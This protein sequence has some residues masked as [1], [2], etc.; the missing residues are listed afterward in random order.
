MKKVLLLG[1]PMGLF[2][3][4][5]TGDLEEV[6]NF[7]KTV[8]GAE[9]NV[10]I[11][12]KRLGHKPYYVSKI[13]KDV[14]GRYIQNFIEK[15]GI[16]TDYLIMD[17]N[18]QT[19]IQMKSKVLDGDAYAPYFRQ[20]SAASTL[21]KSDISSLD[22]SSFDHVHIT[23]VSLGIS[24]TFRNMIYYVIDEARNANIPISFDPNI[25]KEM[26]DNEHE[27][28]VILNDVAFKSDYFLPGLKEGQLLTGLKD[29]KEI[30]E[31]YAKNSNIRAIVMKLGPKG[32]LYYN[33]GMF[34]TSSSYVVEKIVDTVG[35]GDG[36]A[37]GFLSGLLENKTLQEAV[38]DGNAV[39]SM[40][41]LHWSDNQ[42]LPTQDEL[43]TFTKGRMRNN[44]E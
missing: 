13:G 28:K 22:I 33:E 14:L 21:S 6:I 43:Q 7:D 17:D 12:L 24:A 4:T 3:A 8:S 9:L 15:E 2:V 19:G 23:G 18:H 39:G 30:C 11:G 10:A 20:G 41:L 34:D 5:T 35:A 40:Q 32:A 27:M 25:R 16:E 26:W 44:V 42:G 36:F 37:A 29:P 1:E 31:Y 38:D